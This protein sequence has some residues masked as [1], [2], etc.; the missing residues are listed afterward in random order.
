MTGFGTV[1]TAI[2]AM[3]RGAYDYILKPFKVE[4]VI[5]VVQRGPR[6]AAPRGGEPAPARGHL[7]LQ[8]ER[9]HRGEPV[10]RGGPRDHRRHGPPRGAAATSSPRGSTTA[11]ADTSRGSASCSRPTLDIPVREYRHA[12]SPRAFIEHYA[13]QLDA[14]R[15]GRK[16]ARFFATPPGVPAR[17]ARLRPAAHEDAAPR[18]DL[19]RELHQ[20]EALQRGPA[21]AP[22]DRRLARRGGH[23]ERAPLRGPAGDL[24]AD[25]PGPGAAPSTR[26][27][28]TRPGHS[29]RVA[30]YATYLAVRLGLPPDVVEIVRQSALMHDIGKIGCVMNLN[31]PGKLT[32]DEY[33]IFKRHPAYGKDI[34]DPIK[35]LHPL[36]PGRA[37]PPRA[38]GRARVTRSGSR[39]TTSRSSRASS[40]WPTPTTR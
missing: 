2:D 13:A 23:R 27:T 4:E 7:A 6:E 20:A 8:G 28:A 40:P 30:T 14:A 16:G 21:Q 3:K 22:V 31:K 37:P 9:G 29:E 1:E 38:L 32:Q 17:V 34:L 5:R 10:A 35:F 11:R 19:R 36:D 39:A 33:E 15:A 12:R 24:P 26:W 18:L 25:H